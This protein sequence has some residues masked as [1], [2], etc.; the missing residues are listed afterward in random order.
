[1]SWHC[2]YYIIISLSSLIFE[3]EMT[4]I[5]QIK[6][7][8]GISFVATGWVPMFYHKSFS[9]QALSARL[10]LQPGPNIPAEMGSF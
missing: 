9:Q 3:A 1:M 4:D 8:A 6:A 10:A 5:A 2:S 7:T